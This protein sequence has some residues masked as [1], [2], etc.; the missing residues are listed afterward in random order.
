MDYAVV[1]IATSVIEN[2]IVLED[3]A[4]WAPPEGTQIVLL[5]GSF[6]IGDTWDG[7]TFIK[8]IAPVIETPSENTPS[9]IK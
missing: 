1:N 4:N 6:G 9:A 3:G 7:S 5:V 2:V 8:A